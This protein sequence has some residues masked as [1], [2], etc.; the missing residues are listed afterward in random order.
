MTSS[1]SLLLFLPGQQE[2]S[3]SKLLYTTQQGAGGD[4]AGLQR[5]PDLLPTWDSSCRGR[6][7]VYLGLLLTVRFLFL[8]NSPRAQD[9]TAPP[10]P[11]C[12]TS[13]DPH[14]GTV[15]RGLTEHAPRPP[16]HSLTVA[17]RPRG[18]APPPPAPRSGTCLWRLRLSI[19]DRTQPTLPSPPQTRIRNVSNF[20]NKRKLR[21]ER[22]SM[23]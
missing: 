17:L 4:K 2:A 23:K 7:F 20:W 18:W 16:S 12:Q 3:G 6:F 11:R 14:L 15:L 19:S 5:H 21:R 22:M 9:V 10:D 1:S 8:C 13:L